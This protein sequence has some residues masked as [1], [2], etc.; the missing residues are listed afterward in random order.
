[1][2]TMTEPQTLSTRKQ[3]VEFGEWFERLRENRGF[4]GTGLAEAVGVNRGTIRRLEN[5]EIFNSVP[6]ALYE[7]IAKALGVDLG[8][9]LSRA[10]YSMGASGVNLARLGRVEVICDAYA[11]IHSVVR[12]ALSDAMVAL[13]KPGP[14]EPE[15][16]ATRESLIAGCARA[17]AVIDSATERLNGLDAMAPPERASQ[18]RARWTEADIRFLNEHDNWT[19]ADIAKA[20]NRTPEAVRMFRQNMLRRQEQNQ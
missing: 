6:V 2:A 20:L 7:R 19:T 4:T 1:M 18:R 10:G 9:L 11:E 12:A 3:N 14:L 8:Y 15:P 17:L 5:G 16:E 13:D